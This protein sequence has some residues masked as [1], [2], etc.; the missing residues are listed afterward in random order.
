MRPPEKHEGIV[1]GPM[2]ALCLPPGAGPRRHN[3]GDCAYAPMGEPDAAIDL[4]ERTVPR[5]RGRLRTRSRYDSD[6]DSLRSHPR[7]Q[8]LLQRM[9]S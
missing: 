2:G 1:W 5:V 3:D 6:L 8:A 4:L 9:T 7:F